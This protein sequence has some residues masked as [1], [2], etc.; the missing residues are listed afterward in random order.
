MDMVNIT[1]VSLIYFKIYCFMKILSIQVP[2]MT[3]DDVSEQSYS[4]FSSHNG[5]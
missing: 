5:R 4:F 2:L 3:Y 1:F